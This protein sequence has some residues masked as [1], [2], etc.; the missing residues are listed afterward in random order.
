[1]ESTQVLIDKLIERSHHLQEEIHVASSRL[2][3][4]ENR[5][6][7]AVYIEQIMAI[8]EELLVL[9]A[10]FAQNDMTVNEI[11]NGY[12]HACDTY[13]LIVGVNYNK[14]NDLRDNE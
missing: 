13:E 9:V 7:Q 6:M 3:N 8:Y 10:F 12:N 5:A 2:N 4:A 1:M 14:S 11:M